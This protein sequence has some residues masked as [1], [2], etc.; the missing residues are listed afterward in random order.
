MDSPLEN[1]RAQLDSVE[2]LIDVEDNIYQR[3]REPD[4]TVEVTL[5]V[6]RDD[7]T[8]ETFTGY[9]CQYD[10]ARG[11]CKGGIRY[12]PDV[13]QEE[14]QALAGWMTWKCALVDIPYGGAKGGVICDTRD[15]SRQETKR[16]TRRYTESIRD[17]IGPMEDVPA[18]DM[19]TDSQVM[20]WMLDTYS[21]LEGHTVPGVVTGKPPHIGGTE[22]RDVATGTGV[23]LITDA[24]YEYH[25]LDLDGSSVAIQGFGEVGAV[26]ADRLASSG[27]DIVAVSDVSGGIHDPG[28]LDIDAVRETVEDDGFVTDHEGVDEITNDA[29]LE[30][31]VDVVIPAAIGS[32]ITEE[33]AADIQAD[34]II[35][36][37]NGPTTPGADDILRQM[38][39]VAVPDVLTNAGGVIVSYLE[40]VQNWQYYSWS[41]EEVLDELDKKLMAAFDDMI[42]KYEHS[43]AETLREAA[44][45]VAVQRVH[46]AHKSRGLFPGI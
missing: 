11:P 43:D 21:L 2:H 17:V 46:D 20:A 3:I 8:L 7:D 23:A 24:I 6:M 37:A 13:T 1:M 42:A 29:L 28:G 10:S 32:V 39:T 22:G 36:A 5:P 44:Y 15:M 12:H 16:L 41:K 4:K 27:C 34:F 33:N 26:A 25:D 9:R 40:W 31:D 18:P 19:R 14:V 30:M 35:E 45:A 38:E